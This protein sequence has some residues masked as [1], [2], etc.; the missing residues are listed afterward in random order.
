[1]RNLCQ[2]ASR[3]RLQ[4]VVP[5]VLH[6]IRHAPVSSPVLRPAPRRLYSSFL[7]SATQEMNPSNYR[8]TCAQMTPKHKNDRHT[9]LNIDSLFPPFLW[10]TP[11]PLKMCSNSKSDCH[12]SSC[13]SR[14]KKGGKKSNE[15][16]D[17]S[18]LNSRPVVCNLLQHSTSSASLFNNFVQRTWERACRLV[19]IW[20]QVSVQ[21]LN[22]NGS[23]R[24]RPSC[25]H[26]IIL[27]T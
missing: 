8:S 4:D 9:D 12:I 14:K 17:F 22:N 6:A 11:P 5:N 18:L 26:I 10:R 15:N 25:T 20:W 3:G 21:T 7:L 27:C 16:D 1:M 13:R 2:K 19:R 24:A 23:A